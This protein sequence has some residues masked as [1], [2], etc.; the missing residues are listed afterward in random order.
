MRFAAGVSQE[1]QIHPASAN[2]SV[3][4]NRFILTGRLVSSLNQV[5]HYRAEECVPLR[6]LAAML[7]RRDG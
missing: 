7:V 4:R 5:E 2:I 3:K 6:N 1:A